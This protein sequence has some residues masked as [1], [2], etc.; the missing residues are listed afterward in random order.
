MSQCVVGALSA[1]YIWM[2]QYSSDT[3][4]V[5]VIW[6]SQC[7]YGTMSVLFMLFVDKMIIIYLFVVVFFVSF[8]A[9]GSQY[10]YCAVSKVVE[11]RRACN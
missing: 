1:R 11:Y 4:S 7:C 5:C 9:N 6:M 8:Q 2:S 3:M 10:I